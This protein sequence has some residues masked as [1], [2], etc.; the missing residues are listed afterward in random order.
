MLLLSR[1]CGGANLVGSSD[2]G[3]QRRQQ[4]IHHGEL[5]RLQ[6]AVHLQ[7]FKSAIQSM[8]QVCNGSFDLLRLLHAEGAA[9][10][11]GHCCVAQGRGS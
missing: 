9:S 2:A 11:K 10:C 6:L 7:Q 1:R 4:L 5:P 8:S 3:G